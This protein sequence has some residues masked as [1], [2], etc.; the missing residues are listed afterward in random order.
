MLINFNNNNYFNVLL[1]VFPI[2]WGRR[3]NWTH[4]SNKKLFM[5]YGILAVSTGVD[6]KVNIGDY[7][8]ALASAQFLP[9][10]DTYVE[11]ETELHS[12][13]GEQL[14]VIMN[15]WYMNH[16]EN[17]PPSENIN[18][19][20]VALHI[21]RCGLPDFLNDK[22][23]AYLKAHEP[24]GCRDTNTVKLLREKGIEA[25]FSGC[26]T[27]TLGHKYKSAKRA[28]KIYVVEPYTCQ[29]GLIEHHKW[30]STKTFLYLFLH[31][32]DVKMITTKKKENGLKAM[33]YNAYFLKEYGKVFDY[34][35]LVN[36]EY[37]NQYNHEIQKQYPSQED[38][39]K[40]AEFL[41]RNYAEAACVIT[42]R[43]HCALPCLG[44]GTPVI[45]VEKADDDK[46][47]TD[48][49]G[50]LI[51]LFNTMTWDG[52]HLKS[53]IS[54]PIT[55]STFPKNKDDWKHLADKLIA[56]CKAFVNQ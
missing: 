47:S 14:S 50:G 53:R 3:K 1:D 51:N 2:K 12:Y 48:R 20:F 13:K 46:I 21:N 27:L 36:A 56:T 35:M 23:V 17:W 37:V 25:Y 34:K 41:V 7:I 40:Y 9:R 22:S 24:I 10:I 54:S 26:M 52:L 19:L 29:S 5:N 4:T 33:F 28:N 44:L 39:M 15:G 31:Y 45:F 38:K 55:P 43:I 8:Q 32:N 6:N 49:F 42:S 11:R 30:I 16:P 18:P